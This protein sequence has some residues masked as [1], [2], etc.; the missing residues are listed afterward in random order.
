VKLP[1]TRIISC[2][3]DDCEFLVDPIPRPRLGGFS[4]RMQPARQRV[5]FVDHGKPT[6]T[7]ILNKAQGMLRERGVE[8]EDEIFMKSSSARPMDDQLLDRLRQT[9]GLILCGVSD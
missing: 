1:E 5:V 6:S 2:G 4:V 8:V 3:C 7:E 9:E